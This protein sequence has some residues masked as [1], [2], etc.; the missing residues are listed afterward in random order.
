MHIS[1]ITSHFPFQDS[2]S[3]GGIGTSIKNLSDELVSLGHNIT[4]FVYG[5]DND[6]KTIEEGINIVKIKNIKFKGFSWF[7]SRKKIQHIIKKEHKTS[8]IDII[9]TPDW[10]GITSF[11]NLPF[12]VVIRLHG[13]DTYFC[14]LDN[15]K[16]K[17]INKFHEK[18]AIQ[19]ADAY[20]SVSQFTANLTNAIFGLNKKFT[21]I[22]NG[23]N[24]DVFK[25]S[26]QPNLNEENK[27]T[28]K[29]ILYFG[30]IIR[31]KG[32]LEIPHYFNKL[33]HE[34]PEVQLVLI[35]R[36][37]EDKLTGN[38]STFHMM[39]SI[40]STEANRKV[41]FL[42]SVPYQEI[43][44]HIENATVC[45]FPSYAEAL[46]VS[47]IEAMALEKAIV[48]SDIGWSN[49]I[50]EDGV[51]GFKVNPKEHD[52]FAD[53]IKLLLQDNE[54]RQKMQK[55]ARQKIVQNFSTKVIALK[56]VQFYNETIHKN[57]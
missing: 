5:Q 49:E 26:E 57:A 13:S 10:E 48:A 1:F 4:V 37:M 55:N 22:P 18:R 6:E 53:Q 21:I 54:L 9:E 32:L 41:S 50:I 30:G 20:L 45:I 35:G 15:R 16:V 52:I 46:P 23:I 27:D 24:T 7:F 39:E 34:M 40:F 56:A 31:K 25:K 29:S 3:V 17:W 8:K 12:P 43:K 44:A 2:K 47:W 33:I 19:K 38:N 42:G 51:D 36:D 14:H 28:E 11:I